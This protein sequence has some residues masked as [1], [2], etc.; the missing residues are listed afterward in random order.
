M[1]IANHTFII[2]NLGADPTL[3]KSK[4]GHSVANIS[5][6]ID[7][8]FKRT[9]PNGNTERVSKP[10]WVPVV[11]WG[12]LAETVHSFLKKG[13]QVAVTGSIE[14]RTYE[15]AEGVS[16][17]TCELK[18]DDIKFLNNIRSNAEVEARRTQTPRVDILPAA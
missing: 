4:S 3:R 1:P 18:A 15:D 9:L 14:F 6:A 12:P 5:V 13:S 7:T 2:G 8:R 11:A 16:H 17:R 10:T